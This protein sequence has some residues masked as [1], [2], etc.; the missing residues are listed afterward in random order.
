[1]QHKEKLFSATDHLVSG[2]NFDVVWQ[3]KNAIAQTLYPPGI[4]LSAYYE[5]EAYDSHKNEQNS[6]VERLYLFA[7][8]LMFAYKK[9][10]I[11]KHVNGK[12]LLDYGAGVGNFTAYLKSFQYKVMAL[13]PNINARSLV[14][15]KGVSCVHNIEDLPTD[16]SFDAITLWHVLEHLDDPKAV[17]HKLKKHLTQ[18]GVLVLALPNLNSPD[19]TYYQN[20]WAALDV[21]RHLW[22]FTSKGLIA[23][24]TSCGYKH[25]TNYPLF[26]DA[27]YV[28][29]LS[30]RNKGKKFPLVKGLLI[31]LLSNLKALF[32]KEY[33]SIIF[34][35]RKSNQ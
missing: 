25:L 29:Y 20:E 10:I 19:A 34:V 5:S 3:Q 32:S 8:K 4:D 14:L 18:E 9:R 13:E 15:E 23:F 33:S 26:F 35:F 12:S 17:L 2:R 11:Q 24:V 28:A 27:F 22:H 6:V 31:G 1:M 30:E 16:V 7:Q 21:P